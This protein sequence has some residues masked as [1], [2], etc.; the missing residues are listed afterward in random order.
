[1]YWIARRLGLWLFGLVYGL[2]VR[3]RERFPRAG[4]VLMVLNHTSFLDPI[5][6]SF[7]PIREVT[8]VARG[9]LSRSRFYRSLTSPFRVIAIRRGEA[10]LGALREIVREL[11]AGAVVALFPEETRS[12]DGALQDLRAGFHWIAQRA[13]VPIVPVRIDGAFRAWPRHRRL[14][15]PFVRIRM[16]IRAPVD[17]S[18]LPRDAAVEV[19][20]RA[21]EPAVGESH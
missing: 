15:L 4:G 6:A 21:L 5:L 12:P 17:V 11:R 14:P 13:G 8:W 19:V 7:A 9:T 10:D 16:E 20:R 1:M 3:G 18:S 2:Q